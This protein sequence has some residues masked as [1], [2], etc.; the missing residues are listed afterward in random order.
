VANTESTAGHLTGKNANYTNY[1]ML[2][3]YYKMHQQN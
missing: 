3:L 2:M 1:T